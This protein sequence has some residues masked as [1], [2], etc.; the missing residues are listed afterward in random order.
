M[1]EPVG[2]IEDYPYHMFT[3]LFSGILFI[4]LTR[5]FDNFQKNL[6]KLKS[7]LKVSDEEFERFKS[8]IANKEYNKKIY[9]VFPA[10]IVFF[11]FLYMSEFIF[12]LDDG[13]IWSD[14]NYPASFTVAMIYIGFIAYVL[15][16]SLAS[17]FATSRIVKKF[18]EI[19][20]TTDKVEGVFQDRSRGLKPLGTISLQINFVISSI[21]LGYSTY[22]VYY[23]VEG[24]EIP[25][26]MFAVTIPY[27]V[28]LAFFFLYPLSKAHYAMIKSKNEQLE[29][30]SRKLSDAYVDYISSLKRG[31]PNSIQNETIQSLSLLHTEIKKMSVW[32]IDSGWI[33]KFVTS[34]LVAFTA[35]TIPKFFGLGF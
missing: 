12:C 31:L 34:V 7:T 18:S 28:F 9:Y 17:L 23:R 15:G 30:L 22:F 1:K 20:I 6:D 35:S 21:A 3:L 27:F 14:K 13:F 16:I 29:L 24:S 32:P 10:L 8:D 33:L 11:G 25:P 19:F 26:I 2:F 5:L 4:F